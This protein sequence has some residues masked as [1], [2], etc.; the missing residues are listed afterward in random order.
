MTVPRFC[1][2]YFAKLDETIH[3]KY[4]VEWNVSIC[5]YPL[6]LDEVNELAPMRGKR[7]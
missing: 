4:D 6:V 2:H 5:S 3:T 1:T 7:R